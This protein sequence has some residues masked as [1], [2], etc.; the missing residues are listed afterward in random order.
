ME[1]D[2]ASGTRGTVQEGEE[3]KGTKQK[4]ERELLEKRRG[5]VLLYARRMARLANEVG[6]GAMP[7]VAGGY[8]AAE[9]NGE[10]HRYG[11]KIVFHGD[12][13]LGWFVGDGPRVRGMF[14][15]QAITSGF[16]VVVGSLL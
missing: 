7:D 14:A 12:L 1:L 13:N 11:S 4:E 5:R 6:S 16:S 8:R 9:P 3:G 10:I 15:A 2:A